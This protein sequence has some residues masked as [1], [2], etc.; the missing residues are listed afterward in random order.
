MK[1]LIVSPHLSTGGSPQYLLEY[2]KDILNQYT[3][4]K[5]IEFSN[6]SD[7]YVIQKE[8]IKNLI[9]N[10]N[11]ICLSNYWDPDE[12]FYSKKY[13][14][15]DIIS[16][17]APDI[18]WFNEFP[19][20]FEYK[21][22]PDDLINKIY[23]SDRK[24]KIIE[25]THCNN[26]NF[27]NKK[28]IPDEF[29]FCSDMHVEQS[30]K[31]NVPKKVWEVPIKNK[32]KPNRNKSLRLLNLDPDCL[33]V[34]HVGIFNQNK[35]QKYLF[36]LAEQLQ[37]YKIKF[38]FIGNDCYL[39]DC[40]I[41][42]KQLS[43]HNCTIW[44]E[45]SDV[46]KFMSCMDVFIFPS[47][48]ELNPLS[49][50]EALSWKMDVYCKYCDTYV[51]KYKNFE[52]FKLLENV[53][54]KKELIN[55]LKTIENNSESIRFALYTSFY[56]CEK[57]VSKIFDYVSKINYHNFSWF[58]TDDFS[59]DNTKEKIFYYLD[60]YKNIDIKY[61]S[62]NHKKEM[63]WKY[64]SFI[65]DEY[66]YIVLLD[67]DDD[68][69]KNFLTI[70]NKF[71]IEDPDIYFISS[72]FSKIEESSKNLHSLSLIKN[73]QPISEKILKYHP[74][75]DYLN[76]LSYYCWGTLRCFKNIKDLNFEINDFSACAE[77]SYHSMYIGSYG[78]W[79]H[80]PR[81]MYVWNYRL[82]SESHQAAD[83]NFNANFN[84]ALEKVNKNRIEN[85]YR[86]NSIYQETC[87][88]NYL[89][90]ASNKSISIFT[91]NKSANLLYDLFFDINLGMN[92]HGFY[93]NYIIILNDYN[94]LEIT[95]ILKEL[96]N[97]NAKILFYYQHK[98]V[99]SDESFKNKQIDSKNN[100]WLTKIS[101]LV[102]VNNWY[103]YIRHFYIMADYNVSILKENEHIKILDFDKNKCMLTYCL[104]DNNEGDYT[105]N[106]FDIKSNFIL[107]SEKINLI[108]GYNYWTAFDF[109]RTS[110]YKD[111]LV[112]FIYKNH[113]VLE[114]QFSVHDD[115]NLDAIIFNDIDFERKIHIGSFVEV[116]KQLHYSRY[117]ISVEK[118][119]IVVDIGANVG[120]F[121]RFALMNN[122]KKIYSLEPN[123]FC[124]EVLNKHFN[125]EKVLIKPYG[126]SNANSKTNLL[127]NDNFSARATTVEVENESEPLNFEKNIEI[128]I[129]TF[130][131]FIKEN[132]IEKI[133][134][135]KIDCEGCEKYIFIDE[136]LDFFKTS[137]DKIV[138]EFHSIAIKSQIE[139]FL[140]KTDFIYSIDGKGDIGLL[141]A[142]K[143]NKI[144]NKI[145]IINESGSLGDTLA[146]VPI[147]DQFTKQN[148]CDV[149]FY[150]NFKFLFEGVYSRINFFEYSEKNNFNYLKSYQ[151][152]CFDESHWKK[153][154]LQQVAS[155]ILQIKY[156]PQL[157]I[158]KK[159]IIK[160]KQIKGKYICISLQS[161]AQCKYW[162]RKNGWFEAVEYLKNLGYQVICVDKYSGFGIENHFNVMP[163]NCIDM[164]GKELTEV[165][166][167]IKHCEFFIG[168]S[169]GLS[170]L[171]WALEKKVIMISGFS[172]NIH[173]FENQYRVRNDNVCNSCWN[174]L[175]LTFDRSNWLWCPRNK[176]FE[177]SKE[178]TFEMVK[179]KID[180]C[181]DDLK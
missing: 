135:L 96:K 18:V 25:T 30:K 140:S 105:I 127:F 118:D 141:Y 116:F 52:N 114:K 172:A 165:I 91:K 3:E 9:G 8:K 148:D 7:V 177:C 108:K 85:D 58:I 26:F 115:P 130:Y 174:D 12:I 89:G 181:I 48:R 77:D 144:K 100:N 93:D 122:C 126:I 47:I 106:V 133:N 94:E 121:T 80:L 99:Y 101:G 170:W 83:T 78:K 117:D 71:L 39:R 178:I 153:V 142:K 168:L 28:F 107:H 86:F 40:G 102:N 171:A 51:D 150:T 88:I 180:Q 138:V 29:M 46:E 125:S 129:K 173:E 1:L 92:D 54:I 6:F 123:P 49:V 104:F 72:D 24:Y 27:D 131:S 68:F 17:Y 75:V 81:N 111:I 43:L 152:G 137:V 64:N 35:N 61:C 67:A 87:A 120:A 112:Q 164:T 21:L 143:I 113:I 14:I 69:D 22:P 10:D 136:N 19:E 110:I 57:Y 74:S 158:F 31:I 70:Y 146:W 73:E 151:I 79:L 103:S 37:F 32:I 95:H 166:N 66:D 157:P 2:L 62:Q 59:A 56:N 156:K 84:I 134:F 162:N 145:Q 149:D 34:L 176:N 97:F 45:R 109:C 160:E 23:S 53:N 175:S 5:I 20:C 154:T 63:Y 98:E 161:T 155:D 55:K 169:S 82:N 44:G 119:D 76:N 179:Q 90:F 36:D 13:K 132:N 11:L 163:S 167:L 147:V 139:N 38:H 65:S 33:H 41:T 16:D 60:Q 159:N 4:I 42:E 128:D 50:R 15:L 124:L